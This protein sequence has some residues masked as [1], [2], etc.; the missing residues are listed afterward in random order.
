MSILETIDLLAGMGFN[1]RYQQQLENRIW[2][3]YL[4]YFRFKQSAFRISRIGTWNYDL[5]TIVN[6]IVE[7]HLHNAGAQMAGMRMGAKPRPMKLSVVMPAR[8][9][10]GCLDETLDFGISV[11][12]AAHSV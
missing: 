11:T 12:G 6:E 3:S 4:L 9:E 5:P 1:L 10:E 2:R 8:N 7:K